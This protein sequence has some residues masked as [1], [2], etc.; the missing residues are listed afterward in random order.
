MKRTTL[1]AILITLSL[2]IGHAAETFTAGQL[3][4]EFW[5]GKVKGDV[6]GGTA[7]VPDSVQLLPLFEWPAD[8]S[9]PANVLQDPFAQNIRI[10]LTGFR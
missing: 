8:G 9:R 3:Q 2:G 4:L 6:E 7:G 5:Q 1:F 10:S